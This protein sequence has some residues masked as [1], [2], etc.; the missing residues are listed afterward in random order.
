MVRSQVGLHSNGQWLL[1]IVVVA[2]VILVSF[3]HGGHPRRNVR[4][5]FPK[6]SPILFTGEACVWQRSRDLKGPD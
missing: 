2:L 1:L 4:D 6:R 5:I 3:L